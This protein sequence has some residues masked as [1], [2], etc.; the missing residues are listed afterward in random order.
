MNN[1]HNRLF[2]MSFN[3]STCVFL[4]KVDMYAGALFIRLALQWNI[5]VAVA[6]LLAIT[7]VYTIAGELSS[8]QKK[9]KTLNLRGLNSSS[10]P[11]CAATQAAW[12]QSSTPTPPR[13]SSCWPDLSPSWASVSW[14]VT[15]PHPEHHYYLPITDAFNHQAL[16]RLA[17]GTLWWK[18]TLTRSRP[19]PCQTPPAAPGT[20]PSTCSETRSTL[21]CLGPASSSA[22]PSRPCGTGAPTRYPA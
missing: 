22:C 12:L 17:A 20:T 16:W 15:A 18:A 14:R 1:S 8:H 9:Q 3:R 6:L 21:T 11:L 4:S 19:S 2:S 10:W 13:P 7:A 5:Y